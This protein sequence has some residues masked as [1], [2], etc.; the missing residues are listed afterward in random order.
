MCQ[1]SF[2]KCYVINERKYFKFDE[3]KDSVNSVKW[4]NDGQHLA[5]C[6]M[7]GTIKV[8]HS[9]FSPPRPPQTQPP[10]LLSH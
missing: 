9:S 5:I 10:L 7:A 4:S 1:I 6:D 2:S 3:W 8:G